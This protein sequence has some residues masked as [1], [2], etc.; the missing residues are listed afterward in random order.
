MKGLGGG[1]L[2]LDVSGGYD[3]VHC[4]KQLKPWGGK[5]KFNMNGYNFLYPLLKQQSYIHDVK[6]YNG[7]IV[8]YN[9]N[10]M[11]TGISENPKKFGDCKDLVDIYRITFDLPRYDINEP[12]LECGDPILLDRKLVI[13]RSPRYQSSYVF[14]A[15]SRAILRDKGI[16]IGLKKEHELFEWTF[17]LQIPFYDTNSALEVA[18]VLLGSG[19]IVSNSTSTLAIAVGL[20]N[21]SIV[22]E[23]DKIMQLTTFKNKKGMKFI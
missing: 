4:N 13:A 23:T 11:R 19:E 9:L 21:K 10:R 18:K 6:I 2:Y 7:E 5:T 12:W 22:Q 1:I 17:D 15:N 14:L 20:P 16:F 8:N 3:D